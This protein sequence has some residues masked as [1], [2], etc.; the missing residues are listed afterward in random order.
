MHV[1]AA[2]NFLLPNFTFFAEL[3]AF[4]LI[5]AA[6]W[7]WVVPPVQKSL[8]ERQQ[9]IRDQFDRA[10]RARERQEQA[11]ADYQQAAAETRESA[12]RIREEAH[13]EARQIVE[14]AK[15]RARDEAEAVT[16]REQ[17]RL[18]TQR[19]QIVGELRHEIGALAVSLANRIVGETLDDDERQR[20]V[21]ERFLADLEEQDS[22]DDQAAASTSGEPAGTGGQAR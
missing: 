11:E 14:E 1:L 18:E 9:A 6:L 13:A 21:V 8:N 7:R 10:E 17:A 15:T 16:R 2:E 4:I 22:G 3:F 12:A 5:L 19:Q 20:R